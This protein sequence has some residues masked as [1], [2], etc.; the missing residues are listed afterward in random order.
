M[1]IRFGRSELK[2]LS[3][4]ATAE[5]AFKPAAVD[6]ERLEDLADGFERNAK[7]ERPDDDVEIFL[8]GFE[9]IE[10]SIEKKRLILKASLQKAEV[11]AVEFEPEF[12][13]LQMFQPAG[14]Q[15]TPPVLLHP[16]ANGFFAE[17]VAYFFAFNPFETQ[18]FSFA[19]NKDT[20]HFHGWPHHYHLYSLHCPSNKAETI[21]LK[22]ARFLTRILPFR[23]P[24][25]KRDCEFSC[26]FSA[27]C[28]DVACWRL[29][30]RFSNYFANSCHTS[31]PNV[32]CW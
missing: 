29:L 5:L 6:V 27:G 18:G 17:I 21:P 9:T 24:F 19:F 30:K 31:R 16:F 12:F 22:E 23:L 13:A 7:V 32:Y 26:P 1:T 3:S 11:A 20:A 4:F 10:N 15:I 2:K 14:P 8:T 28:T 25:I